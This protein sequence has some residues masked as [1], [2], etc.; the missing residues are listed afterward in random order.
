MWLIILPSHEHHLLLVYQTSVLASKLN[1]VLLTLCRHLDTYEL[2]KVLRYWQTVKRSSCSKERR[3]GNIHSPPPQAEQRFTILPRLPRHCYITWK[4]WGRRQ[5]K[6]N[7]KGKID[8]REKVEGVG[9]RGGSGWCH[10]LI[11]TW[12]DWVSRTN[13]AYF[14]SSEWYAERLS[15]A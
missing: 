1:H 4:K 6:K 2:I 7:M 8:D 11:V 5:N 13:T 9:Q 3:R 15:E 10:M 14:S 12:G